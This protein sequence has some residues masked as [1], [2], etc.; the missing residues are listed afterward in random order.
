[1]TVTDYVYND[2]DSTMPAFSAK[3][4]SRVG[5]SSGHHEEAFHT[6]IDL[7]AHAVSDGAMIDVGCG[8][9]R[10]TLAAAGIVDEVVALEPDEARWNYTRELVADHTNATVL[11]QTTQQFIQD[12]PG[13]RFDLV[14]LG[15]VIQHLPTHLCTAVLEDLATL[16]KPGGLTVVSTTH[17][18]E[19]ARCFTHQ[20]VTEG[21]LLSQITEEAFNAYAADTANQDKGLP[22]R[23]FSRTEF[24]SVVPATFDIVHWGQYSYFREEHIEH[25]AWLH[26][27]EPQE[28]ADTGNSQYLVLR[29]KSAA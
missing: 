1:M 4:Y 9:G 14:V 18:L 20:H 5:D 22:V 27:V 8:M 19:K 13:K 28:L 29:R 24:E 23:R 25:F 12:N 11:Q 10:T 26:S 17:A 6:V 7:L 15:M 21:R 2:N 16:C 3:F